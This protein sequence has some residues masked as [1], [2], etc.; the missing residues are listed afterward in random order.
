MGTIAAPPLSKKKIELIAW[1]IRNL[2]S[3]GEN[4]YFPIMAFIE[5]LGTIK[6]L[7]FNYEI[8]PDQEMGNH[9]AY[10]NPITN[11]LSMRESVYNGA[12]NDCGRDR[13]TLA[14]E[15]GHFILHRH[16]VQFARAELG[17]VPVYQDPEWQANTFA[18]M[19]LMPPRLIKGMT[20]DEVANQ[21]KTSKQAAEIALKK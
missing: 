7:N 12:Y 8:V 14:H 5:I 4:L 16:A 3:N 11:V 13:F 18:S 1:Q 2:V 21:C 9:Y 17:T 15:L 20:A 6:E 10:Y 19:F